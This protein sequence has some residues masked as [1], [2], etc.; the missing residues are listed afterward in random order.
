LL[1]AHHSTHG[2]PG[3]SRL[4]GRGDGLADAGRVFLDGEMSDTWHT[5]LGGGFW[6]AFLDPANAITVA[7]ARGDGRTALYARAGFAY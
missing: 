3:D 1:D 4:G 6:F 7:L 2:R 5:G